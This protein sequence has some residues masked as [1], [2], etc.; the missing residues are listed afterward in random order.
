M[1]RVLYYVQ[2]LWGLGHYRRAAAVREFVSEEPHIVVKLICPDFPDVHGRADAS[3]SQAGYNT[4]MD[5]VTFGVPA[6]MVPYQG[7]GQAEQC[8]RAKRLVDLDQVASV[9]E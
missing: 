3:I 8:L 7:M 4:A 1:P 9:S 5:V 6:V 2:H